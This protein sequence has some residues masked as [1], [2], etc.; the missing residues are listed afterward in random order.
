[1][2]AQTEG[3]AVWAAILHPDRDRQGLTEGTHF[4]LN[5]K[6]KGIHS[7]GELVIRKAE[8]NPRLICKQLQLPGQVPGKA[9]LLELELASWKRQKI[10]G[11]VATDGEQHGDA[12]AN[13]LGR[14]LKPLAIEIE[15]LTTS[16]DPLRHQP[17]TFRHNPEAISTVWMHKLPMGIRRLVLCEG[18][19]HQCGGR[20]L[21]AGS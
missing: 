14:V 16:T 3:H 18:H 4:H 5:Q 13:T 21:L 15:Q 7:A 12:T 19:H 1:M 9:M 8:Q 20:V 2:Q 11:K 17:A 10:S 6:G